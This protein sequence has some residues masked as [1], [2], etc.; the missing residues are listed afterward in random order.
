MDNQ[1]E[2]D[3]K[4][5]AFGSFYYNKNDKRIW[6]N[7]NKGYGI[8]LNMANKSSYGILA[9]I[10]IPPFFVIFAVLIIALLSE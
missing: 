2:K 4:N 3:P 1:D 7:R 5:R 6:I 9:A 8:T 10:L